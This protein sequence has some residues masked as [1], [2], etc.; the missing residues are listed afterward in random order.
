M[1]SLELNARAARDAPLAPMDALA[2][3]PSSPPPPSI[4]S[5]ARALTRSRT[6]AGSPWRS[7]R[8]GQEKLRLGWHYSVTFFFFSSHV[9]RRELPRGGRVCR[10]AILFS[11]GVTVSDFLFFTLFPLLN[12]RRISARAFE[13]GT[14]KKPKLLGPKRGL[15]QTRFVT[16]ICSPKCQDH[17]IENANAVNYDFLRSSLT[18]ELRLKQKKY[19]YWN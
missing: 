8:Q 6:G 12:F 14:P 9:F 19:I 15:P 11:E 17:E 18:S 3:M 1:S 7:L 10:G 13:R 2:A 16:K 5:P 4:P